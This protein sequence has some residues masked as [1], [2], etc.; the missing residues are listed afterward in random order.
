MSAADTWSLVASVVSVIVGM[1]AIAMSVA[2]YLSGRGTEQRV[3][4]SLTKIETQT[5]MLQKI[6]GKQL[7]RLTRFAID[8]PEV[9]QTKPAELILGLIQIAEP[10][11]R[12]LQPA[13]AGATNPQALTA[14]LV[15]CYIGL[16]YYTALT[17]FWA[18]VN[19]P[20]IEEF[21][22]TNN[23]HAVAK[24]VVD[25]SDADFVA[26]AAILTRTD[27]DLLNASGLAHLLVEARDVWRMTVRNAADV[28]LQQQQRQ[29]SQDVP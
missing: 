25:T 14:E 3:G 13:T 4:A 11:A 18:Q 10:L 2:F 27:Q 21:D 17:N 15:N 1:V 29:Q 7:D 20:A 22:E 26:I 9:E 8:R 19:L 5:E 24:R 12:I 23:L 16:Y 28:W 6:T